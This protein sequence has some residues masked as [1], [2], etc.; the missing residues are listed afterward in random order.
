METNHFN[1]T[2]PL[3]E[4]PGAGYDVK[5]LLTPICDTVLGKVIRHHCEIELMQGQ[6]RQLH[7]GYIQYDFHLD[8]EKGKL[9]IQAL[10]EV[11][12]NL[13]GQLN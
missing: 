6:R 2:R 12:F 10:H 11:H 9:F 13:T 1:F 4:Q 3:P 5:V 7:N 8:D